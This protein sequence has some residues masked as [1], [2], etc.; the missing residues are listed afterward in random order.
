MQKYKGKWRDEESSIIEV[1]K[2]IASSLLADVSE[3]ECGESI[4]YPHGE[5]DWLGIMGEL[6]G[7]RVGE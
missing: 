1:M 6:L 7:E 2:L 4:S 5:R 3:I